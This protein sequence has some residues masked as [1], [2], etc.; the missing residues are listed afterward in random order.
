MSM[1]PQSQHQNPKQQ[2]TQ[3]Y[4]AASQSGGGLRGVKQP[5]G[6]GSSG[7]TGGVGH[8]PQQQQSQ[9]GRSVSLLSRI[10]HN[11]SPSAS[12]TSSDNSSRDTRSERTLAHS[13]SAGS[14]RQAHQMARPANETAVSSQQ[15]KLS[16]KVLPPQDSVETQ[17]PVRKRNS[18]RGDGKSGGFI[19]QFLSRR[20]SSRSRSP[21]SRS[22]QTSAETQPIHRLA[23]SPGTPQSQRSA[24]SGDSGNSSRSPASIDDSGIAS[25]EH[26]H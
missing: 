3:P 18:F 17:R 24:G 21:H 23:R 2:Q 15:R 16:V 14:I 20:A 7:K 19:S 8:K 6:A 13:A 10:R 25:G 12:P 5:S 1:H 11:A 9:H 22:E 26:F 4:S